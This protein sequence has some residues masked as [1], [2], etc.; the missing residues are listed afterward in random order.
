[1][2]NAVYVHLLSVAAVTAVWTT[3]HAQ[4]TDVVGNAEVPDSIGVLYALANE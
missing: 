2:R 4:L 1:M 3:C